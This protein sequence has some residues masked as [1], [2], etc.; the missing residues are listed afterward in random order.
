LEHGVSSFEFTLSF[1]GTGDL[2][3]RLEVP[4]RTLASFVKKNGIS[5]DLAQDLTQQIK[6][7]IPSASFH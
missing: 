7:L 6:L 4:V 1:E 2:I 3:E 5:V